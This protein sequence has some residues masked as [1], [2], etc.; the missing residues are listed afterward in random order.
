MSGSYWGASWRLLFILIWVSKPGAATGFGKHSDINEKDRRPHHGATVNPP[1]HD[2]VVALA[3]RGGVMCSGVLLTPHVVLTAGHCR[4]ATHVIA[5]AAPG[6]R[7]GRSKVRQ[8]V[9]HPSR[10]V[11]L[12]LAL[13]EAPLNVAVYGMT[14]KDVRQGL[15]RVL[16]YGCEDGERCSNLGTRRYFD[17]QLDPH[18]S[19]CSYERSAELGCAPTAEMVLPR[20][21]GADTCRGDSGGPL[22]VPGE[23]GWLVAAITSRGLAHAARPCGEGGIY[24]RVAPY[25]RWIE[26]HLNHFEKDAAATPESRNQ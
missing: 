21:V 15:G 16:G 20:S 1:G 12:G 7:L 6:V 10:G 18:V 5:G 25:R 8:F 2:A 23:G 9:N 4:G 17:A 19:D 11:D 24:V 22:L 14:S 3:N 13:L 26:E